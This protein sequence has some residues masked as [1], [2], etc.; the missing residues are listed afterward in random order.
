[1]TD[2]ATE[3]ATYTSAQ[4]YASQHRIAV[5]ASES[6]ACFSC[7]ARFAPAQIVKWIDESQT[8]L[9]PTCGLDSVLGAA[10][11]ARMDEGFLRKLHLH[12]FGSRRR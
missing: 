5:Q 4:T 3:T 1:M 6:C 8:A 7:F 11:G 2:I 12:A 10:S 9:C